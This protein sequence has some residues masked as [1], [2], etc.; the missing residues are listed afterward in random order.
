M[1]PIPKKGYLLDTCVLLYWAKG[2]KGIIAEELRKILEDLENP[3]Y[4]S[5]ISMWEIA[6]KRQKDQRK[7]TNK[8]EMSD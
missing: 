5:A 1:R 8:L 7:N 2:T 6:I 4:V 3:V